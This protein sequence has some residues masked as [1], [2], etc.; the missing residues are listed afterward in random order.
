VEN[1]LT[2]HAIDRKINEL[3]REHDRIRSV[4]PAGGVASGSKQSNLGNPQ[5]S[6]GYGTLGTIDMSNA[7]RPRD[8]S[9]IPTPDTLPQVDLQEY[10]PQT[11]AAEGSLERRRGLLKTRNSNGGSSSQ[12]VFRSA[13]YIDSVRLIGAGLQP[14]RGAEEEE[15]LNTFR[16]HLREPIQPSCASLYGNC[17]GNNKSLK[18]NNTDAFQRAS[19]Y[20][21]S[22]SAL[23]A[24]R[25]S[26][27][28]LAAD[29][30]SVL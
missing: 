8:S 17:T 23:S 26:R 13:K 3:K 10:M 29:R 27:N 22:T 1:N 6:V 30:S 21:E 24:R 7:L 12:P 15:D 20:H 18:F 25:D 5:Q 11:Q 14:Q 19:E 4:S 28:R 16:E 2:K 9:T